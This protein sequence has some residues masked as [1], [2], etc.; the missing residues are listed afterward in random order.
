MTTTTPSFLKN[1]KR[2]NVH[3]TFEED[4]LGTQPSDPEIHN[5]FIASKAPDALSR[6]EET[7]QMIEQEGLDEAIAQKM[8][9]FPRDDE[10]NPMYWDYQIKGF[11]KDA[12]GMLKRVKGTESSKVKAYKKEIDGTIF[13]EPRKIPIHLPEGGQM[14]V[15]QRPLRASTAQ[16]ERVSLASSE[17]IPAG[18]TLDFTIVCLSPDSEKLV[19]EWLDYGQVHGLS[20]WRSAGF[21]RFS[22]SEE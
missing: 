5:R 7:T 12:C 6:N 16:G 9:V 19:N 17:T 13:V 15:L 11:M 8:T 21:G 10:G 18:S 2:I 3:L 22:W 1:A 14:G 20:Q 4:S